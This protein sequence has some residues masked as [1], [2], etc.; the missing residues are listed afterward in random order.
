ML[1]TS[2]LVKQPL[3]PA[4]GREERAGNEVGFENQVRLHEEA[5]LRTGVREQHGASHA[6]ARHREAANLACDILVRRRRGTAVQPHPDAEHRVGEAILLAVDLDEVRSLAT[7]MTW[8]TA[9]ANLPYGGAKGGI[10]VD[11]GQLSSFELQRLTRTFVQKIHDLIGPHKDI[12]APDMGTSAQTMGWIVDEYAKFHGWQPGVVTGN[13]YY[14]NL[15]TD[16]SQDFEVPV[17]SPMSVVVPGGALFL[18]VGVTDSFYGDNSDPN[19]NLK[20]QLDVS[21]IPEPGTVLL[22]ASGFG[23]LA[24]FRRRRRV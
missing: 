5:Q 2:R 16:I 23:L 7:L 22:L 9:V 20:L 11:P 4:A 19:G 1:H 18:A 10:N 14:G 12:P 6:Q 13:T 17:G 21:R 15:T 8:K 3:I 24:A